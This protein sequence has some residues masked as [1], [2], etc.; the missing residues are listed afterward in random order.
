MFYIYK[1]L[2]TKLIVCG[3][4]YIPPLPGIDVF[5]DH[6]NIVEEVCGQLAGYKIIICGDYN[7]PDATW[8]NDEL[9]LTVECPEEFSR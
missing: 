3:V 5:V 1:I 8:D 2:V 7:I 6:C 4:V 9:G